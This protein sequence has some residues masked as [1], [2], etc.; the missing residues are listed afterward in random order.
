MD[1]FKFW[2]CFQMFCFGTLF[3]WVCYFNDVYIFVMLMLSLTCHLTSHIWIRCVAHGNVSAPFFYTKYLK[4]RLLQT[5]WNWIVNCQHFHLVYSKLT[6]SL[7][8][9]KTFEGWVVVPT[10]FFCPKITMQP[11]FV[12]T[13]INNFL[14]MILGM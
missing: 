10:I 14:F 12:I 1:W 13:Q 6:W 7:T 4:L 9:T 3:F 5:N 2:L 8:P 11:L